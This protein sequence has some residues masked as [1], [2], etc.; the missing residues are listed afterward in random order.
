M[1]IESLITLLEANNFNTFM[2]RAEQGTSCPYVVLT[3]IQH[4]NFGADNKVFS[5]TTSLTLRLVESEVHDWDLINKLEDTLD[6][7]SIYY[8]SEDVFVPEEHVCE[9]HYEITFFGGTNNG[10]QN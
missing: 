5:K 9:T 2:N 3:D 10:K 4:P 7:A 8:E 6:S 1:T